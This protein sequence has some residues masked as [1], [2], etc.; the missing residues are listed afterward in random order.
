M[1]RPPAAPLPEPAPPPELDDAVLL[2]GGFT[3]NP[4]RTWGP[5]WTA[6]RWDDA[7]R[8][9]T[10][11]IL[12][13]PDD[14]YMWGALIDRMAGLVVE[15]GFQGSRL[16]SLAREFGKPAVFGMA[17]ATEV[18]ENGQPVTLCADVRTVYDERREAVLPNKPAGKD[19]M[20]GSP[21]VPRFSRTRRATSCP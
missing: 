9:P 5:A 3:V 17:W 12:V 8:F 14:N 2:E 13:V 11:G 1:T 7:R 6:R 16:A 21:V 18:V 19:Y 15:R 20:P 10:G 4:G